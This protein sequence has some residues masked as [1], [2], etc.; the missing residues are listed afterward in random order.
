MWSSAHRSAQDLRLGPMPTFSQSARAEQAAKTFCLVH[1]VPV[2]SQEPNGSHKHE[3]EHHPEQGHTSPFSQKK[4][5]KEVILTIRCTYGPDNECGSNQ[6]PMLAHAAALASFELR[7]C[8]CYHWVT[9]LFFDDHDRRR[10]RS[11]DDEFSSQLRL[12]R[13]HPFQ[14]SSHMPSR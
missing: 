11:R 9:I 10:S 6:T 8:H 14:R 7:A 2:H 4:R 1:V 13:G 12:R 5:E 3:H